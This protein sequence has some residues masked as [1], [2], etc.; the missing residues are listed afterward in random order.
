MNTF[1]LPQCE[2][3]NTHYLA[4][5]FDNKSESYKLFW[6][7]A[8]LEHVLKG[9]SEI[10][11]DSLVN[12]MLKN[13]WYM[14]SEYKLNLGPSDAIEQTVLYLYKVSGIAPSEK[15]DK[16]I[17][18]LKQCNDKEFIKLKKRLCEMVPYRLQAPFMPNIT[19]SIWDS[20]PSIIEYIN[21][22]EDMIYYIESNKN[23]LD[24]RVLITDLWADYL[25]SNAGILMGW[26]DY[27][28]ITYLQRRNPSVPGISNKLYP[29]QARQL[30]AAKE[31]WKAVIR[32]SQ[33]KRPFLDIYSDERL[34]EKGISIDHFVPWSY[35]AHDELWNLIPTTRSINSSKSNN[36]P[37][38]DIYFPRL[39]EAEYFAYQLVNE[40]DHMKDLQSAA[41]K[42]LKEHVNDDEVRHRLYRGGQSQLEF[43]NRLE[44]IVFPA[45][46]SARNMGFGIWK[47]GL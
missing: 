36:L 2:Q 46:E 31:Y 4:H 42:C 41:M 7:K 9:E 44:E 32:A 33:A 19:R 26:V 21:M 30:T 34:I 14:V 38:W 39:C 3:L 8:I 6:F 35:V 40:Y 28:L 17:D 10:T 25:K 23:V 12:T 43:S 37:E 11:F 18:F 22:Q 15:E 45:Y 27:N 5:I 16:I 1:N 47:Y 13:A 24:M 29:P 20:K